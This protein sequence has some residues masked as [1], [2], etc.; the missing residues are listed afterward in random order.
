MKLA[1][2][3]LEDFS[4]KWRWT[5]PKYCLIPADDLNQIL[6]LTTDSAKLIWS[7]SLD[8]TSDARDDAAPNERFFKNI[9]SIE[10]TNQDIVTKWLRKRIAITEIIVS[11]QPDTAVI[12]NSDIFLRYWEEFCYPGSD[13][14]SIWPE[15]KSW[16]LNYW[17]E[18]MFFFGVAK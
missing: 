5:D 1:L 7:E 10:N 14:I 12:T 16:V 8:F 13:D 6:P 3:P 15:D 11:W 9:E 2:A 4:L 17:H 18:E